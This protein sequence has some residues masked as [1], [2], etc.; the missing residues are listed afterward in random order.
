[1]TG[2]HEPPYLAADA[3]RMSSKGAA[4]DPSDI[5]P[6]SNSITASC[7]GSLT[8]RAASVGIRPLMLEGFRARPSGG[9]HASIVLLVVAMRVAT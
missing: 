1:V 7:W 5:I 2:D 8:C 9:A 4:C 3:C 6:P